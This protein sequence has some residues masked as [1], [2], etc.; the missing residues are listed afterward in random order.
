MKNSLLLLIFC[1]FQ[2]LVAHAQMVGLNAY[3]KGTSVEIGINGAGGFEGV[4]QFVS[5][6]PAG[7]HARTPTLPFGFVANPQVNAWATYNGDFFTPG[8]PENG[9]GFEIGTAG[10][11]A[12]NNYSGG[13]INIPGSITNYSHT[14]TCYNV[15]WEGSCT[16]GTDL[17]FHI[18][19]F[20]EETDLFYT[21]TVTV[22]N[23]TAATITDLY[24]YR[25]LDPDNNQEI[26]TDFT[27]QN[28]IECQ[29]GTGTSNVAC[30]SATSLLPASQPQSYLGLAGIGPN[31]RVCYGGFANRDASDIWNGTGVGFVQTV[32]ST[33]FADEAISIGY[34]IPTLAAGAS[35][36]FKFV[37]ILDIAS[38]TNIMTV[39]YPGS[40]PPAICDT[41]KVDTIQN[42]G[43]PVPLDIN[44][45]TV[46]NYTWT[47][48][49]AAG[50]STA[51]GPS[52][53]ASPT[54]TTTYTA[55]GIPV[56][57]CVAPV[58]VVVQFVMEVIPAS[59]APPV[60]QSVP[61]LC[62]GSSTV[63]LV[64]DSCCG[65]WTGPGVSTT[66]EFDPAAAGVGTHTIVYTIGS[67]PCMRTDTV[68]INVSSSP[69]A[70]IN[71]PPPRCED[72]APF[73]I[74]AASGGGTWSGTGITNPSAGTFNPAT[75]GPGTHLITYSIPGTCV[76]T[77]T[78]LVTIGDIKANPVISA[79]APLCSGDPVVALSVDSTG[80]TWSGPGVSSSGNFDP[81][82]A[83]GGNHDIIY[84]IGIA[85]CLSAD[86]L[87][88]TVINSSSATISG[89]SF[90]CD[91][92]APFNFTAAS[93]GG[94]WSGTGITDT[95]AGTFDPSA[96][97]PGAFMITYTIGGTCTATDTANISVGAITTPVT[98]F[99]YPTSPIC[100]V[101]TVTLPLPDSAFTTGGTFT[102]SP[103]GLS[104]NASTG[105]V[106][107]ALS[108]P[109]TYTVTYSVAAT[110]CGPAGSSTYS[111]TIDPVILPTIGFTYPTG[112]CANDSSASPNI[113]SSQTSGGIFT[114][115]P[116][117]SIDDSTGVINV[118]AST[119]GTY[120]V[121]Y[122]IAAVDSLCTG[123][124][125]DTASI[126]INPLPILQVT[127]EQFIWIGNTAMLVASGG[128]SY[129]WSPGT[130]L[131]CTLCDTTSASPTSTTE[132]CV[133]VTD[134]I[135]CIDSTCTK[136]HIEIPCPT[137]RFLEVPN[138]FTPNNDGYND[139]LCLYG[140]DNCFSKFAIFVYD[141]WGEMVYEST[142]PNFCWDGIYKG[143]LLDPGVFVYFIKA[144][145]VSSGDTP[146]SELGEVI[147]EKNGNIS[148]VH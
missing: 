10:I 107:P 39:T 35:H 95:A 101:D 116:G 135:G 100:R 69:S 145:Y 111:V 20:L 136:V 58:P 18:N 132:Y 53:V 88:I 110:T 118:L 75:S 124:G 29:P 126:T 71:Q 125:S 83:G 144:T 42:C 1:F 94:V 30:V 91:A 119:P 105:A 128:D 129:V 112:V 86:T 62:T 6:P 117:L 31:F 143:K 68:F 113:I 25:N 37:V 97:G 131:S 23:N 134:T 51:S 141:R 146:L 40:I 57:P 82:V 70:I 96:S 73:N 122:S 148:I 46:G 139:E 74:T 130:G 22:T 67:G 45:S 65:V 28:T 8:S 13:I 54:V 90:V 61:P 138:A 48:S 16:S 78:V 72:A 32:G 59:A 127:T 9:W 84:T 52:T 104:I 43:T 27:T 106:N 34:R 99:S 11:A 102:S 79:V 24:Y 2:S 98:G 4:D 36:T 87:Q 50:L 33:L 77:D 47:W 115:T 142:D 15:D 19:Y 49:P 114:S 108:T 103:F 120:V 41:A 123:A 60:I 17:D 5:P 3:V 147:V 137:N 63:A 92:S 109:G 7:M 38:A 80:G 21:T 133:A 56:S 26:S 85:P 121:Q 76:A 14:G 64:V 66:G 12:S 93:P 81:A 55:T 89:P 140:W 44:G